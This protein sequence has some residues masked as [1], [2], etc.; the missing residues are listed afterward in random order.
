MRDEF[1]GTA[2]VTNKQVHEKFQNLDKKGP[3]F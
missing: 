2:N 3:A 1:C